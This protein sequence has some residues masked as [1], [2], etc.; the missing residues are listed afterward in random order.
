MNE[1]T[2]KVSFGF[3]QVEESEKA[4]LVH[5]VFRKVAKRYDLMNDAMS[6]GLHRIWKAQFAAY[7]N[8]SPGMQVLDVAGGTGD[9]AFRL[10]ANADKKGVQDFKVTLV[11]I[12]ENML[13]VG[14]E[15]AIQRGHLRGLD[16]MV[17]DAERLSLKDATF[18]AYTIAF[19][20]RNC[21]HI[22]RVLSEA[23]RVLKPGG[24]FLSLELSPDAFNDR[25]FLR[26]L[27]DKFSFEIIPVFGQL[28]AADRLSYQYLVESIRK[29]PNRNQFAAM[30]QEA[31]FVNVSYE[32]LFDGVS[33]IHSAWKE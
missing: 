16:W 20:I 31:G 29:F 12:N 15:R 28:L 13:N 1:T 23:H 6:A 30:I 14:K 27:Y 5:E 3:R 22:D 32:S 7:V 33:V 2:K 8:P 25:P 10:I 21:T 11:D 4:P 17:G 24:Q 26:N 18:D 9:I 19:G